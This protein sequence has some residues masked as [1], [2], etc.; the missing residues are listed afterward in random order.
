MTGQLRSCH[1]LRFVFGRLGLFFPAGTWKAPF[2]AWGSE[3]GQRE[4]GFSRLDFWSLLCI[5]PFIQLG[6]GGSSQNFS[7]LTLLR[8]WPKVTMRQLSADPSAAFDTYG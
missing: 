6:R 1:L 8:I 2:S 5:S 7:S 4:T 3:S